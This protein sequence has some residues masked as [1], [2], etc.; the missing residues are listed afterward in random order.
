SLT[1]PDSSRTRRPLRNS[2][3]RSRRKARAC[4]A[5]RYAGA[6]GAAGGPACATGSRVSVERAIAVGPRRVRCADRTGQ[7]SAQR[8]LRNGGLL[9]CFFGDLQEYV[10]QAAVVCRLLPQAFQRPAADEPAV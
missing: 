10:L 1:R 9:R 6:A 2:R 7:R 8:T 5:G 4:S 3:A